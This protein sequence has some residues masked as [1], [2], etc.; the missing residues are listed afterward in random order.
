MRIFFDTSALAKRYVRE[1]GSDAVNELFAHSKGICVSIICL[2]E[3]FSALNRLRRER[4]IDHDQYNEIKSTILAEFR[5]FQICELAPGTVAQAVSL[6]EQYPLRALDAL[7][8]ACALHL[9]NIM[10]VSSDQ[11]QMKVARS[12]RLKVK[13]I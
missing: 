13:E 2:P 9:K 8:L 1:N 11:Q 6:L 10:F 5:N 7:Q 4:A 12:L 3:M